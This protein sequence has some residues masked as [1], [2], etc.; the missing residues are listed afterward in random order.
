MMSAKEPATSAAGILPVPT[1]MAALA[2]LGLAEAWVLLAETEAEAEALAAREG[3]TAAELDATATEEDGV[4]VAVATARTRVLVSVRVVVMVDDAS[5]AATSWVPA[6]KMAVK[7]APT[8]I[9]LGW[10]L[11][12]T[13]DI[14]G[15]VLLFKGRFTAEILDRKA[16]KR[17]EVETAQLNKT[18]RNV[19]RTEKSFRWKLCST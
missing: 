6:R 11:Y 10:R 18:L 14:S 16:A 12:T 4:T 17:L 19:A 7:I 5:S 3:V 8:R 9:L 13:D 1:L 15:F 2:W